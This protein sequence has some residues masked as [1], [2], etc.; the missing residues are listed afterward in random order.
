[1][2]EKK[3]VEGATYEGLLSPC[4]T[5]SL[6]TSVTDAVGTGVDISRGCVSCRVFPPV[7]LLLGVS[8]EDA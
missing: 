1:M 5:R 3:E 6:E 8:K 7:E 4:K 2:D